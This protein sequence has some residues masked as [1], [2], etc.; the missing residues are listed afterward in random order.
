MYK[1]HIK[2]IYRLDWTAAVDMSIVYIIRTDFYLIYLNWI[3]KVFAFL[4]CLKK[5]L[6]FITSLCRFLQKMIQKSLEMTNKYMTSI[7][8]AP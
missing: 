2:Q 6:T 3:K 8:E 5:A 4:P 1:I 7:S